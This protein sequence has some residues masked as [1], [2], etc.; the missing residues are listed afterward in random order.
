[1][2][3]VLVDANIL[4]DI[5]TDD[6]NWGT[7][8][9][10]ALA[11]AGRGQQLVINPLIYAEVSAAFA[12]I[13]DLDQ[14]LPPSVFQR[15]DLPW[16]AGFLAGKAYLGYRRRGGARTSPLPDFYIGAHAAVRDYT[17]LTRD[18]ARYATYFPTVQLITP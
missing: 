17:L 12:R 13:E 14:L 10:E 11:R 15:E 16:E 2:S 18:I 9:A 8:S 7:W 4:I 1:M 3:R 5:A 6:P